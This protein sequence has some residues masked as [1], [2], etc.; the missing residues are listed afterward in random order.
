MSD[1]SIREYAE[2]NGVSFVTVY[3]RIAEIQKKEGKYRLPTKEEL[4][5]R[6]GGR[7]RKIII[8]E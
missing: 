6:K 1:I 5:A 3:K 4:K 8:K 7:P 2:Q